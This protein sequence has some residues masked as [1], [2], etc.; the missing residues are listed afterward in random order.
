VTLARKLKQSNSFDP[1]T[2]TDRVG[3]DRRLDLAVQFRAL[4]GAGRGSLAVRI[5]PA[6]LRILEW[7]RGSPIRIE[8]S[9]D[10]TTVTMAE[11][12]PEQHGLVRH[13]RGKQWKPT[14]RTRRGK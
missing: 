10:G 8:L 6:M 2:P 13:G 9:Q 4:S 7:T 11:A 14:P 12:D 3:R 5:P 1:R